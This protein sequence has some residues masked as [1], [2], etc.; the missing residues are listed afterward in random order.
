MG[1]LDKA[2]LDK[3]K[4]LLG[5]KADKVRGG[6]DKAADVASKKLGHKVDKEKI[7]GYAEKAKGAVDKL[8]DEPA[9]GAAGTAGSGDE[10]AGA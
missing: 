4:G 8:A 10:P 2:K 1:L 5:K 9:T 6:I 3:A 7:D